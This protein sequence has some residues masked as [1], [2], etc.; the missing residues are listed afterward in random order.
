[1]ERLTEGERHQ[2]IDRSCRDYPTLAHPK[3]AHDFVACS[4]LAT[5]LRQPSGLT[6]I[7]GGPEHMRTFLLTAFGHSSVSA[8]LKQLVVAGVDIHRPDEFVPVLGLIYLDNP[9]SAREIE[10]QVKQL[11]PIVRATGSP[12]VLLNDILRRVP[13]LHQEI[14]DLSRTSHVMV[15]DALFPT[16]GD[17]ISHGPIPSHLVTVAPARERT[18]WIRVEV[19]VI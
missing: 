17:L 15:A 13:A 8:E 2:L 11:W 12:L 3:L 1:M 5:L 6:F 18:E 7:Q 10:R 4:R 16:S 9:L 19:R 14:L